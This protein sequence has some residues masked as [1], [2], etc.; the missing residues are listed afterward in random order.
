MEKLDLTSFEK[1]LSSLKA[2][3]KRYNLE[4]DIDLRDAVIQR[5]EYTYSISLKSIMRFIDFQT[6][7][8]QSIMTFN[9]IIRTANQY[10]LLKSNLIAWDNFRKARNM[11]SHTYDEETA[12]KVIDVIPSFIVEVDFLL[13]ELKNKI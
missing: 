13:N 3:V 9:E 2:I 11:T 7:K 8:S 6:D 4:G 12:N 10:G 1:A 5:F